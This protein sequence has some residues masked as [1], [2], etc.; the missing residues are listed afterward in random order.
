MDKWHTKVAGLAMAIAWGLA[1]MGQPCPLV[2]FCSLLFLQ[3]LFSAQR[4]AK[5]CP[6]P[7]CP[8]LPPA[9]PVL[10]FLLLP[11]LLTRAAAEKHGG[12]RTKPSAC[13]PAASHRSI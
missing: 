8:L 11:S 13:I 5:Y 7:S 4:F 3:P 2:V 9:A 12:S 10:W 1:Q 6:L